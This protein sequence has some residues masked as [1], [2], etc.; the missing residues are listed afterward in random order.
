METIPEFFVQ[1]TIRPVPVCLF[2]TWTTHLTEDQPNTL[3]GC[4]VASCLSRSTQM[5]EEWQ[6]SSENTSN[7]LK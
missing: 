4:T 2:E 3:N 1:L 5:E 6:F 7:L